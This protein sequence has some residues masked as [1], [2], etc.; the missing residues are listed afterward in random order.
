MKKTYYIC[1]INS[2]GSLE[3][4]PTVISP[5]TAAKRDIEA[6]LVFATEVAKTKK[7]FRR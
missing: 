5:A 3:L 7:L 6:F 4:S 2:D 1:T